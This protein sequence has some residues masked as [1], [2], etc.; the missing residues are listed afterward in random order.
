[1][2]D[3][4]SKIEQLFLA[5][6][7]GNFASKQE[8]SKTLD[9]VTDKLLSCL[10]EGSTLDRPAVEEMVFS[11]QEDYGFPLRKIEEK[12]LKPKAVGPAR[13]PG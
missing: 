8:F 9:A 7:H 5:Q 12:L 6:P 1:M 11:F 3:E 2:E 13:Q 10:P 4:R